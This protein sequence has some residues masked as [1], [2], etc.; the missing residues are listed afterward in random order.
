MSMNVDRVIAVLVR[1]GYADEA[2]NL[3]VL[4]ESEKLS[5]HQTADAQTQLQ[6][7]SQDRDARRRRMELA[8]LILNYEQALDIESLWLV[9]TGQHVT[10]EAGQYADWNYRIN[11]QTQD[12]FAEVS[13]PRTFGVPS[14]ATHYGTQSTRG[15][16]LIPVTPDPV[17]TPTTLTQ[18]RNF[19]VQPF[20]DG[21]TDFRCPS[22]RKDA[23]GGVTQCIYRH[24]HKEDPHMDSALFEW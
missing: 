9:A 21:T 14:P 5:R 16:S 22:L 19:I 11:G 24:E 10:L 1:Q 2:Q 3:A 18:I 7:T 17:A 13:Q 20:I 6:I 15:D 8:Q 4:E 23:V 12:M